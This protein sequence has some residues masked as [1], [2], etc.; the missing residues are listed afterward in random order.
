MAVIGIVDQLIQRS[1]ADPT[2]QNPGDAWFWHPNVEYQTAA[3]LWNIYMLTVGRGANWILNIPPNSTGVIPEEFV[4]E[5]RLLGAGIA[6]L[7]ISKAVASVQPRTAVP[8]G[9]ALTL[10]LPTNAVFDT[11]VT[12]EELAGGQLIAAYTLEL[13]QN[14]TSCTQLRALGGSV[15]EKVIDTVG[16]QTIAG[17]GATLKFTP[18][19]TTIPAITSVQVASLHVCVAA[20]PSG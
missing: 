14:A 1:L 4:K 17:S 11:V 13:C 5:T 12:T 8:V 3:Q 16:K 20:V 7:G 10:S 2:V 9:S 18:T 6:S 15:G 19:K